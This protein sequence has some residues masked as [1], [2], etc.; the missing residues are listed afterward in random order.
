MITKTF[1]IAVNFNLPQPTGLISLPINSLF[2]RSNSDKNYSNFFNKLLAYIYIDDII[3]L[4][5]FIIKEL[6]DDK[7][8]FNYSYY[9]AGIF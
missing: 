3:A 5:N 8:D 2:D 4:V 1:S 6:C 9:F 7:K